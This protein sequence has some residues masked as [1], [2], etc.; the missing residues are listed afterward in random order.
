MKTPWHLWAVGLLSLIWNAGGAYDYVMTQTRNVDYMAM[1]TPDQIAYFD[2]FP[3]WTLAVWAIG[4]WGAV[5]G[6]L[7]LLLRS[8]F[9]GLSFI[10]SFLGMMVNLAYGLFIGNS[11][12]TGSMGTVGLI[13]TLA[14]IVISIAL[15]I[16]AARMTKAGVLS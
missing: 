7:L 10:A 9:A 8:R 1:M 16:Y 4:V 14:I 11:A 2:A 3:T 5:L 15:I 13:F 12:M 6:S